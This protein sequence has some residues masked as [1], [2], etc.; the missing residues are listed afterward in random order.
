MATIAKILSIDENELLTL[1]LADK[2]LNVI[3][4]E[5][6]LAKKALEVVR[7]FEKYYHG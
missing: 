6:E 3:A 2:I 4:N 7:K 5:K 1:W